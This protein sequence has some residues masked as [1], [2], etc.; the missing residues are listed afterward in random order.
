[1]YLLPANALAPLTP[2][3]AGE[4]SLRRL[5]VALDA[6]VA[7]RIGELTNLKHARYAPLAAALAEMVCQRLTPSSRGRAKAVITVG[8]GLHLNLARG[9]SDRLR[10]AGSRFVNPII[11]PNTLPSSCASILGAL[12]GAHVCAVAVDGHRP[13][14]RALHMSR[15]LLESGTADEVFLF[16][17][18]L[19]D[20]APG[21]AL[22]FLISQTRWGEACLEMMDLEDM[23]DSPS[24][25]IDVAAAG[26]LAE[27]FAI[28]LAA[29]TLD[30]ERLVSEPGADHSQIRLR[31]H[32][33]VGGLA[34]T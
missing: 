9:F 8:D 21:L 12:Y 11:F 3:D 17:C 2:S 1:M 24:D 33:A 28:E 25:G 14:R 6:S 10:E 23:V 31:V 19:P 20:A 4:F 18:D 27:R 26:A 34:Q 16:V 22:G 7:A 30:P 29:T 15:L 32:G 13:F 5:R